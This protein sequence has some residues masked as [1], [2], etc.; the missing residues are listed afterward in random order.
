M[1]AASRPVISSIQVHTRLLPAGRTGNEYCVDM[2]DPYDY[3]GSLSY[4][5]SQIVLTNARTWLR[6]AN[7]RGLLARHARHRREPRT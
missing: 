5:N 7:E 2:L 4:K 1:R 6:P 3:T